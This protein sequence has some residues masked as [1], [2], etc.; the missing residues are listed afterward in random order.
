MVRPLKV[1][2]AISVPHTGS[3]EDKICPMKGKVWKQVHASRKQIFSFDS[4]DESFR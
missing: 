3:S 4:T 1:N 2:E